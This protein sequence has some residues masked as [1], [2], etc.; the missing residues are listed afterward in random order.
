ML[1]ARS[2]SRIAFQSYLLHNTIAGFYFDLLQGQPGSLVGSLYVKIPGPC[3]LILKGEQSYET[4]NLCVHLVLRL[5]HVA[6]VAS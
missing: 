1:S 5:P 3:G 6:A 4:N 2:L